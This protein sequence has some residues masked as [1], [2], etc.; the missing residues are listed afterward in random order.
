[1]VSKSV[2]KSMETEMRQR[3]TEGTINLSKAQQAVVKM[4]KEKKTEQASTSTSQ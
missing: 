4:H 1:M 3:A 2:N